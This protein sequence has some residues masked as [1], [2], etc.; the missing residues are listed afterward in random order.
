MEDDLSELLKPFWGLAKLLP[1]V[2]DDNSPPVGVCDGR[3]TGMPSLTKMFVV[4]CGL[5]LSMMAG[6]GIASAEP[7]VS[8]IINSTCTYP[9]VM[10]ALK[11]QNPDVA[12]QITSNPLANAWLQQLIASPPDGRRAMVKQ[13]QGV[14]AVQQYSGLIYQVA[15]T[16]NNY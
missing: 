4:S 6:G 12:N 14:P 9:Q 15:G 8:P 7:D 5:A 3:W 13:A 16:C 11:A 1:L 2:S 10:G